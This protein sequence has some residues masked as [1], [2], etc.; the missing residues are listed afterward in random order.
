[1][2]E[3]NELALVHMKN[4]VILNYMNYFIL[5]IRQYFSSGFET[6]GSLFPW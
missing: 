3:G 6:I 5:L 2:N 4:V 1:M